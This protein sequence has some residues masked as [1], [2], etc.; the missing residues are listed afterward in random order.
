M[1]LLQQ[2]CT[3]PLSRAV[4]F[5]SL[6]VSC[7]KA[8]TVPSLNVVNKAAGSNSQSPVLLGLSEQELQQLAVDFGQVAFKSKFFWG[9]I[10]K[11]RER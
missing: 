3:A 4:R 8:V 7:S 1:A 6:T 11:G 5:R 9:G 10:L 2:L